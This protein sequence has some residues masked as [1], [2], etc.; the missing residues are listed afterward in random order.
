MTMRHR[1]L[2]GLAEFSQHFGEVAGSIEG[3]GVV[4]AQYAPVPI[5]GVLVQVPGRL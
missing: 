1:H 5:Q 3:V 2:L 4:L